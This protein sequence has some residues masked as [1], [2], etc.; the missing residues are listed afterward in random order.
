[1]LPT[2]KYI[3]IEN[4]R[5]LDCIIVRIKSKKF[6]VPQLFFY[7]PT[8]VYVFS[9]INIKFRVHYG[10]IDAKAFGV[11]SDL[12]RYLFLIIPRS[13]FQFCNMGPE[14]KINSC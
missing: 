9:D 2:R 14:D 8:Y 4:A 12:E 13:L 1:M 10:P 7:I 5:L 3:I 6:I 11:S